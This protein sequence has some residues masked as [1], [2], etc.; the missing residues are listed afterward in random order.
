MLDGQQ[1]DPGKDNLE[2]L[3]LDAYLYNADRRYG[4]ATP[5]SAMLTF[6]IILAIGILV[7]L[8]AYF[9]F[10]LTPEAASQGKLPTF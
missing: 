3:A 1:H 6:W 10:G 2:R 7:F 9:G 4:R 5:K 8:I